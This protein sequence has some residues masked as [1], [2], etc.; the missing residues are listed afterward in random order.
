MRTK[1][2]LGKLDHDRIVEAIREAE[3]KT[4]G[5]IRVFIQRGK[6]DGDPLPLAEKKF[7]EFGMHKTPDRN[8]TLIL[9]APRAHKFAVIGDQGIH[10]KCGG[11]YWQRIVAQMSEHFQGER[12][13]DAIVEAV[14]EIGNVLARHFPPKPGDRN[15][16][17]D[18]VIEG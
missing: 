13:T 7:H 10:E 14:R 3:S 5:E 2:F 12:F 8:A 18:E 15:D 11:D 6:L 4:S 9:L 1:E 17:S 16:L